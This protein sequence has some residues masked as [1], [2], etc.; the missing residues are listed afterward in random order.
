MLSFLILILV[1]LDT[2]A[3]KLVD[4]ILSVRKFMYHYNCDLKKSCCR[5]K[6]SIRRKDFEILWINHL[7]AEVYVGFICNSELKVYRIIEDVV[8]ATFA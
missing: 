3:Y 5:E 7:V 4:S 1:N 8:Y 2:F 6:F